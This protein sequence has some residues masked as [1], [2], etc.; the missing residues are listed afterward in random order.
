MT[1]NQS[2]LETAIIDSVELRRRV[3]FSEVHIWRLERQ[4]LFPRRVKI[5]AHRVGWDLSEVLA[6]IEVRKAL[7]AER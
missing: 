1:F 4:G 6:W 2:I 3:P 7:R 5:G